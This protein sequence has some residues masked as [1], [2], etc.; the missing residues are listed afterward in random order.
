MAAILLAVEEDE[1]ALPPPVAGINV[2]FCKNP[3]CDNFGVPADIV[4]WR[5]KTHPDVA[6]KPG[7][8]YRLVANGKSRPAL[9]CLL[10][11]ESF[12]VKSNLAVAEEQQRFSRYLQPTPD[13]CCTTPGCVNG[14]TPVTDRKAYYR[15]GKSSTGAPR[16]RCRAC[17]KTITR[18]QKALRRQRTTH[19]NKTI[20][21]A[22]TNK[23]P[24]K[25]ILNVTGLN[26]AT[27]YGKID[28]LYRQCQAFSGERERAFQT[29]PIHRLYISV[30]RQEYKVNWSRYTDRRNIVLRAVGSADN[31]SG[32]VFG[33]HVNFDPN[34]DPDAVAEDVEAVQDRK[35][36]YPHRKYARLWLQSDYDESVEASLAKREKRGLIPQ[37]SLGAKIED[38][39]REAA[40]REDPEVSECKDGTQRLPDAKGMQVHEEYSLYGH[41]LFLKDLLKWAAKIRFFLDQDSGMRAACLAA[42]AQDV[43]LRRVDAFYV[44]TAKELTVPKKQAALTTAKALF[45]RMQDANPGWTPKEIGL[46]MMK[47][48][49]RNRSPLGKWSDRWCMHPSPNMSEPEKAMCWL[50]EIPDPLRPEGLPAIMG[51]AS[52][53]LVPYGDSKGTDYSSE[54]D[55]IARLFLKAS[56]AGI[57]NFFQRVR[58][59]LNPLERP[60]HTSSR[61]GRTWHGY[62]PYNPLMVEKLLTIYRVMHNYVEKGKD[63]KTPAMRIGLANAP[64]D[65]DAILYFMPRERASSA[66]DAP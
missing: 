4:K 6:G 45:K 25:R 15:F 37:E 30:D 63:G 1:G 66:A 46:E 23:M 56:V 10:C 9:A 20:L 41:F 17:N 16:W 14:S 49:I 19:L 29:L 26:A 32:F 65:T 3:A 57:D 2:N 31:A 60:I 40:E 47:H 35:K 28:F 22:L 54:E 48:E 11:G 24:I 64:V 58:R 62:S 13:P 39:Y 8:A 51:P 36:P 27:L 50:T 18:S 7:I 34:V 5:R 52:T 42:F 44:R 12:S 43:K 33:M 59:R 53:A 21:L 55:H 61:A 38:S